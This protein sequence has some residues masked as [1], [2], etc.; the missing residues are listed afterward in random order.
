MSV[1][2]LAEAKQYLRITGTNND[3]VIQAIVDAC[4]E[5]CDSWFGNVAPRSVTEWHDG[6][7]ST[8]TLYEPPLM[9]VESVTEY[10]LNTP[11]V[12]TE[13]PLTGAVTQWGYTL[14]LSSCQL[15]RRVNGLVSVFAYGTRN[16]EVVYTSGRATV[17]ADIHLAALEDIRG[18]WQQTQ[19]GGR[20]SFQ[21]SA[22]EG[23]WNVGP[24]HQ[25][26]RLAAL[27]DGSEK[28]PG[29]A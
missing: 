1:V 24:M 14:E 22:Q 12:L 8:I 21:G 26:P 17:P 6:G 16:V 5:Q 27:A 3:V 25:F 20:P 11:Y 2:T 4:I 29:L 9:S 13:Q 10:I 7:G 15:T 28:L 18:L 23:D 19:Q